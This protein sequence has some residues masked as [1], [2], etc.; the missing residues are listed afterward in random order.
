[1]YILSVASFIFGVILGCNFRAYIL[2]P[3]CAVVAFAT[4]AVAIFVGERFSHAATYAALFL[5]LLQF[6][7]LFGVIGWSIAAKLQKRRAERTSPPRK[8]PAA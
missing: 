4:L 2:A 7:Y 3:S 6:G 1:M 8:A 5:T